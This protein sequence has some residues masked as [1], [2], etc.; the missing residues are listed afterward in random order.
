MGFVHV[1]QFW[2]SARTPARKLRNRFG[3][4]RFGGFLGWNFLRAM[5]FWAVGSPILVSLGFFLF[6][7]CELGLFWVFFVWCWGYFCVWGYFGVILVLFWVFFCVIFL[8]GVILGLF[9]VLFWGYFA[10]W[11]YFG[12][13][14]VLFGVFFCCLRLFCGYLVVIWGRLGA[15]ACDL[16]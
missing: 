6:F 15:I 4:G 13:I 1:V 12:V 7:F 16:H 5:R 8:F 11:G 3:F 10:V 14:L 9:L 2:E